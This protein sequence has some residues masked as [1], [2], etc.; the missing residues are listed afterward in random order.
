[1]AS[2]IGTICPIFKTHCGYISRPHADPAAEQQDF[3]AIQN[4]HGV[5]ALVRLSEKYAGFPWEFL[6]VK[7]SQKY[8]GEN[9]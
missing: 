7:L 4:E 8:F 5:M 3:D 2:E 1:M 9:F 6:E